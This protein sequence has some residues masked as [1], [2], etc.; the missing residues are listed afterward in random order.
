MAIC[1]YH[2]VVGRVGGIRWDNEQPAIVTLL[3]R[4]PHTGRA[5]GKSIVALQH[6][7]DA[8][9]WGIAYISLSVSSK[10]LR[11]TMLNK[12]SAVP[13]AHTLRSHRRSI[14]LTGDE[15]RLG[16]RR[17]RADPHAPR[18]R[19]LRERPR[20]HGHGQ[21]RPAHITL[22]CFPSSGPLTIQRR[23]RAPRHV[24][25]TTAGAGLAGARGAGAIWQGN[26]R[27]RC[28]KGADRRLPEGFRE[29]CA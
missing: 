25:A 27:R 3:A 13:T 16:P 19:P 1:W 21:L 6:D 11:S 12:H 14:A 28:R 2:F 20:L 9:E 24:A 23:R 22:A 4:L 26:R 5:V 7:H 10:H 8:L 15:G 18:P 29:G 17:P